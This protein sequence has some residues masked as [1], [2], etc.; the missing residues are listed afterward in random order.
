MRAYVLLQQSRF[1]ECLAVCDEIERVARDASDPLLLGYALHTRAAVL[2]RRG[3]F[4]PALELYLEAIE[5]YRSV[6]SPLTALRALA[7]AGALP[8]A[9][10]QDRRC[11]RRRRG[12]RGDRRPARFPR[13]SN[14]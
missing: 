6:P 7:D 8:S 5:L 3:D 12:E 4:A 13:L 14:R 2:L 11:G 10:G 9:A 1:D